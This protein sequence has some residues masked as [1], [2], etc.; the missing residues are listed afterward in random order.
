MRQYK[1]YLFDFDYTL[2]DSSNGIVMCFRHVL[3]KHGYKNVDD[4]AIKR[5]IGMTLDDAFAL[6]TGVSGRE[7][8]VSASVSNLFKILIINTQQIIQLE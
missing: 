4:R 3:D 8:L 7:V 6:L 2:V 1:T 5:T